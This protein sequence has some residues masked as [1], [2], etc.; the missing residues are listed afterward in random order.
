MEYSIIKYGVTE[1]ECARLVN[2][3]KRLRLGFAGS[4]CAGRLKLF[5]LQL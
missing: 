1:F 3:K 4:F 5:D 2:R